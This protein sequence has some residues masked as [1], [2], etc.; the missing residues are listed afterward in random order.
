MRVLIFFLLLMA[1]GSIGMI[2]MTLLIA[3]S[4]ERVTM[5]SVKKRTR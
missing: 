4:G 1:G 3:I 5:N 2:L